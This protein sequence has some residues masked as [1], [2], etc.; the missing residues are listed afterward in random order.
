MNGAGD[1]LQSDEEEEED[2][3]EHGIASADERS[4]VCYRRNLGTNACGVQLVAFPLSRMTRSSI[5]SS[6]PIHHTSRRGND[7]PMNRFFS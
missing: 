6:E 1:G 3:T 4:K 5:E 7:Q 2:D